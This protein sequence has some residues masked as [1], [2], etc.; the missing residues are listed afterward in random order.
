ML[1]MTNRDNPYINNS[2]T[3]VT[4]RHNNKQHWHEIKR[5]KKS[6]IRDRWDW[7]T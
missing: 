4:N 1:L 6:D 5:I 2:I 7:P 3:K